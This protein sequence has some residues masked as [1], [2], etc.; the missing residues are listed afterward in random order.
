MKRR[1]TRGPQGVLLLEV[2]LALGVLVLAL[3]WLAQALATGGRAARRAQLQAQATLLAQSLLDQALASPES[4]QP[5]D[6]QPVGEQHPDWLWSLQMQQGPYEELWLVELVVSHLGPGGQADFSFRL[7]R[8]VRLPSVQ[9]E[10]EEA[11]QESLPTSA[12]P[13]SGSGL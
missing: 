6:Q 4:L 3:T 12:P 10:S 9:A 5:V 2:V 1:R 8:Y 11:P 7:R 13:S